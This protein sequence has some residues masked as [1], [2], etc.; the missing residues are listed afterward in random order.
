MTAVA[1]LLTAACAGGDAGATGDAPPEVLDGIAA[2]IPVVEQLVEVAAPTVR[3]RAT[4]RPLVPTATPTGEPLRPRS[5]I[6]EAILPSPTPTPTPVPE[7][8]I[9][10]DPVPTS[11]PAPTPTVIPTPTPTQ[12]PVDIIDIES[13]DKTAE[14]VTIRNRGAYAVDMS[15]WVLV[16]QNGDE[17][18]VF[19]PDYQ[20][21][22]GG[23][24]VIA[25][26]SATGDLK[27]TEPDVWLDDATD[28]ALLYDAA[29]LLISTFTP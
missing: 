26:G 6:L 12:I 16:S 5:T 25:S 29:G 17:R 28:A 18:F 20:V 14:T 2:D 21:A 1:L 9:S 8:T 3:P 7:P 13:V 19:P 10:T 24:V 27:W 23:T 15:S 4:A 22:A 11:T